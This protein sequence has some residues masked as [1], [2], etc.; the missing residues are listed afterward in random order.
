MELLGKKNIETLRTFFLYVI[1][2]SLKDNNMLAVV[3]VGS[4]QSSR[5]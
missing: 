5:S 1:L 2:Y 4:S 3:L